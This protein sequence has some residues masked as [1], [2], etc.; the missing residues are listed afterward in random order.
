MSVGQVLVVQN[1]K[2]Y[3]LQFFLKYI[4]LFLL[5]IYLFNILYAATRL[6]AGAKLKG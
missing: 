5:F 3:N 2:N 1:I 6:V 4:Y